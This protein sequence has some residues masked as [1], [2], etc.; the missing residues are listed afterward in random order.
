MKKPKSVKA[1]TPAKTGKKV[2]KPRASKTQTHPA[3]SKFSATLSAMMMQAEAEGPRPQ[4]LTRSLSLRGT[5]PEPAERSVHVFVR[6]KGA[7]SSTGSGI[8]L[9][10]TGRV[11]TALVPL[12]RMHEIAARSEVTRISAPRE[13]RPLMDLARPLV[14]V[15]QFRTSTASSGKGVLIGIVD[16]GL[17][18]THPAFAG[19][20]LSVWDQTVSGNGP[21]GDFVRL[22]RVRT[23]TALSTS[24]DTDGHGTHV[25]GIA[26]GAVAPFSGV[27]PGADLLVVKTNFQNTAIADGVRWVFSEA[28]RL[29]RPAVV[30][31]SLG[32]HGDAHDGSDD[33]STVI[34]DES[35]PGRIVVVAAGNE[36]T[37]AIH[38]VR[39]PTATQS[40]LFSIRVASN[41]SGNTPE[42]FILNGWYRGA[43]TCEVRLRSSTGQT[44]PFQPVLPAP[45]TARNH[46]LQNDRANFATPPASANPNGDHQFFIIVESRFQGMRVQGGLW[47]LEVRRTSGSPGD[48]HV[49]LLLPSDASPTAAEFRGTGLQFSHLIG[50]PGSS[51]QAVTVAAFTTRNQWND[52][53]GAPHAVGLTLNTIADFS[54]PGPLRRGALKP[55]VSAPGAMIVSALSGASVTPQLASSIVAPGFLVNAGT[56]MACPFITGVIALLLEKKPALSPA[57]AKTFLKQRSRV[58][59]LAAGTHD[60][61]WGHGLLKL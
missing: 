21:G 12:S 11:R 25:A 51:S 15:P 55:D 9:H 37:D 32:G 24:R 7:E 48:V 10:G 56:S 33:L 26:S 43:G 34:D 17:D 3:A 49:W 27:A 22:G 47:A 18:T 54:S 28:T 35:G 30:N 20:V 29:G 44:T 14:R 8:K 41:T 38:A 57:L 2:T 16:S 13:L 19:R 50:S 23:G 46:L 59:G 52:S 53:S 61:K 5:G 42:F 58:P 4:V 45:P 40:A 6:T 60:P 36:G 31:L 1:K 39:R